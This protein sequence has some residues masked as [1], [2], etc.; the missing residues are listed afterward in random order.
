MFVTGFI[1]GFAGAFSRMWFHDRDLFE[2]HKLNNPEHNNIRPTAVLTDGNISRRY[3]QMG[4]KMQSTER[5]TSSNVPD[6]HSLT[7]PQIRNW[8]ALTM[9]DRCMSKF[10]ST[11][12]LLQSI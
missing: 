7:E 3:V 6:F 8:H 1:D 5:R 2:E 12:H 4:A 10:V 9:N 11:G